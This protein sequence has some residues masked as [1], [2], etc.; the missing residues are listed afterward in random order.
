[1]VKFVIKRDGRKEDFIPE[2]VVVSCVKSGADVEFAREISREIEKI[3]KEEISS[4]EIKEIVFKK[5]E[6]KNPEWKENWILYD[7]AVKKRCD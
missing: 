2:K 3:D 4:K 5:F 7:K 1:M 6:E